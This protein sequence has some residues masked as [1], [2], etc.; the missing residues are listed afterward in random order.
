MKR[1]EREGKGQV[2]AYEKKFFSNWGEG[3]GGWG[4]YLCVS[5]TLNIPTNRFDDVK[6]FLL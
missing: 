5:R 6:M 4:E 1:R 2:V 3:D